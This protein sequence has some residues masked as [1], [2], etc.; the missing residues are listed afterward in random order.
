MLPM[1][2]PSACMGQL[3]YESRAATGAL[4]SLTI[5]LLL[6]Q[7]KYAILPVGNQNGGTTFNTKMKQK[8]DVLQGTLALMVLKTLD[9]LGPPHG[10]GIPRRIQQISGN[11]LTV[12]QC[13]EESL[14]L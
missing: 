12:A 8:T 6:S 11:L 7:R 5:Y 13:T 1:T 14:L 9:A 10:Y 4:V 2:S 3:L